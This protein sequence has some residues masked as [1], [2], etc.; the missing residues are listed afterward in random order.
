MVKLWLR[1]FSVGAVFLLELLGFDDHFVQNERPDQLR[2]Y[3]EPIELLGFNGAWEDWTNN[4]V[5]P[6]TSEMG[7]DF[8]DINAV[9]LGLG[10]D[11]VLDDL[12]FEKRLP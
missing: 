3:F 6:A 5:E 8:S 12:A 2:I 7:R 11:E 1:A 9:E 4:K 10:L